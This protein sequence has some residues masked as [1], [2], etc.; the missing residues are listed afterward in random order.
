MSDLARQWTRNEGV[1]IEFSEKSA[2]SRRLSGLLYFPECPG[3]AER[4]SF[5]PHGLDFW[6]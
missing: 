5:F 1:V 6:L 3:E 2:W 4:M